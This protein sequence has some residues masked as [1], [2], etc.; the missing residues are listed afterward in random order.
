MARSQ[1]KTAQASCHEWYVR[2]VSH[3]GSVGVEEECAGTPPFSYPLLTHS[4][5]LIHVTD[6]FPTLVQMGGGVPPKG[7]HGMDQWRAITKEGLSQRSLMV[8]N[9]DNTTALEAGIR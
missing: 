7:I 3:V 5:R 1:E 8:Y 2:A 4:T 6:W 9:I